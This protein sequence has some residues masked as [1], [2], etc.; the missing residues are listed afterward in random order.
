MIEHIDAVN[1]CGSILSEEGI[2]GI[3]VGPTDLASS[4]G[5]SS[6]AAEKREQAIAHIKTTAQEHGSWVGIAAATIESAR[7]F[8]AEGF[9]FV[10]HSTDRR[11]LQNGLART[12]DA[13][14]SGITRG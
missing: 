9:Q 6:E 1:Q 5:E 7:H 4:I 8:T 13:W 10:V 3:L 2:D 14:Q 12:I 11:I